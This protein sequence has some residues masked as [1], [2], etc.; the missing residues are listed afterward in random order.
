MSVRYILLLCCLWLGCYTVV[1]QTL[2]D[3]AFHTPTAYTPA[4]VAQ[5]LQLSDGSRV[6]VAYT[7]FDKI[8]SQVQAVPLSLYRLTAAGLPDTAFNAR[9]AAYTDMRIRWVAEYPG[10]KL[11]GELSVPFTL[12][13]TTY[14]GL[15]RFNSDGSLDPT[16]AAAAPYFLAAFRRAS[17]KVQPDGSILVPDLQ[18]QISSS[19]RLPLAKLQSDGT[20]DA[21]F[22]SQVSAVLNTSS[23][24]NMISVHAATGQIMVAG[25]LNPNIGMQQRQVLRLLPTGAL[26]TT[27]NLDLSVAVNE[28]VTV[29]VQPDGK[30]LLGNSAS[31]SGLLTRFLPDGSRD[32]TFSVSLPLSFRPNVSA[33]AN[34]GAN[35]TPVLVQP[36]GRILVAGA[37]DIGAQVTSVDNPPNTFIMRLLSDGSPDPSWQPAA[38]GDYKANAYSCQLLANGQLLVASSPKLYASATAVPTGLALLDAAGGYQALAVPALL[39]QGTIRSMAVQ[40]NGQIVAGGN[41]TEI[42]GTVARNIVR[43]NADGAIDASFVAAATSGTEEVGHVLVQPDGK[44]L[45][46]GGFAAVNGLPRVAVARLLTTGQ[47]DPSFVPSLAS[48]DVRNL[49][50]AFGMALQPDGQVLLS[51]YSLRPGGLTAQTLLRLSTTGAVDAS[52]LPF[53]NYR[54]SNQYLVAPLLVQPNGRIVVGNVYAG[55]APP[56]SPTTAIVQ[57][58][59]NGSLDNQFSAPTKSAA[60]NQYINGFE[61]YPD[62]RLLL[63]G[64]LQGI[65]G[66][67]TSPAL[68]RLSATGTLDPTFSSPFTSGNAQAALIQPNGRLL[69]AGYFSQSNTY[70]PLC[71]V[72][73]TGAFDSSFAP[74]QI[75]G[76]SIRALALQPDGGILLGGTFTHPLTQQ[77]VV[78]A[79]L[80]DPN[81]LAI[82]RQQPEPNTTAWPVPTHGPLYLQLENTAGP[83]RV[84]LL[85]ALGRV[86]LTQPATQPELTLPTA[87]LPAG[88]YLLRVEYVTGTVT[89]RVVVE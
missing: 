72:L 23:L 77:R 50:E 57:L 4:A 35:P 25:I 41:F 24:V 52:F 89:R 71:R 33:W 87:D 29:L 34:P 8:G 37:F 65:G 48:N 60:G 40:A 80:L 44:V 17:W 56:S 63:Y 68:A 55:S 64:N 76:Y 2:L 67:T 16:F 46:S 13:G 28:P 79:R 78:L 3:P 26:D 59:P 86:V 30:I 11:L 14:W 61:R 75:P 51:G 21:N 83:R 1:A 62:G 38:Y 66:V 27:F 74:T 15:V 42:N 39:V 82:A 45:V 18:P 5:A 9:V 85:D 84:Q 49:S 54:Y 6:L 19:I 22:N 31:L 47:P 36:D 20:L 53:V 32:V 7:T 70:L 10:N 88:V 73:D 69:A 58:L 12:G 81:V 43:F